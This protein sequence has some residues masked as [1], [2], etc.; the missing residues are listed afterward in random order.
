[1]A[2]KIFRFA[3]GSPDAPCSGLWRAWTHEDE[4]HLAVPTAT[5]LVSITIYPTGRWRITVG[6]AVSRWNRPKDFRLGWSR[7]PDLVIPHA[8]ATVQLSGNDPYA[9]EPLTW[10]PPPSAGYQARISLLIATP[11]AEQSHWRPVETPGT[12]TLVTLPLRTAGTL[13][14]CRLDEPVPA[15][16]QRAAAAAQGPVALSVGVSADQAGTP[17][18]RESHGG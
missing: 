7:G 9:R 13:H 11:Q 10:L 16:E 17:S 15:E 6:A 12:E 4:V 3:L 14:L 2:N 1:M 5:D 8:G 18:F